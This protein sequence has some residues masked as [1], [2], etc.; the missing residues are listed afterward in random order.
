MKALVLTMAV[1]GGIFAV[2]AAAERQDTDDH[3]KNFVKRGQVPIEIAKDL[4]AQ[5]SDLAFKG[6]LIIAGTYQGTG[7]F[8]SIK[9]KPY[10][11]QLGFLPCEGGQGDVTVFGNYVFQSVDS[12]RVGPTCKPDD[13]TAAGQNA[14]VAGQAWEGIRI[15]DIS[16]P[17]RPEYVGAVDV[18]C[19]SHT[20]TLLP[21][22]EK[23]Y[24][25]IESYPLGAQGV[26]CSVA[27]HR[28]VQIIEFPTDDPTKA[29]LTDKTIDVSPAIGCHD[30]STFPDKGLMVGACISDSRIWD[31]SK[32]PTNPTLLATINNPQIS[33]HHSTALTWDGKIL[34]LG[35]EFGGAEG[36]GCTGDE[37][38]GVGAAWFYDIT[39]PSAPQM[40]GSHSLPRVPQPTGPDGADRVRCTNH[41]FNVIPMKDP[42]KYL[43]AVSYYMGGIAVVDFSDPTDPTEAGYY[44]THPGGI[45]QD[46]WS[47]YWYQGR[48]YTNDY[49]SGIGVGVYFFKGTGKKKAYFFKKSALNPSGEMN[50]QVQIFDSLNRPAGGKSSRVRDF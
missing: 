20:N 25:Y 27:T 44:V 10:V 37:D 15:I 50:P 12:P 45:M 6:R 9:K 41:N 13:S 43:L 11:R 19:G 23:S 36:G 48:I 39:D 49:L 24:L 35:D 18:P 42:K 34:V 2:P 3:S 5:G 30:I 31:I 26:D 46:T 38:S 32:D 47:A 1:L 33:I 4:H 8:T 14:H 21:G 16:N 28:K 17:K 29:K 22:K 40:L 7:I